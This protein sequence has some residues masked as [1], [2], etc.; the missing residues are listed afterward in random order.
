M[1]FVSRRGTACPPFPAGKVPGRR[2]AGRRSGIWNGSLPARRSRLSPA[3][4]GVDAW[5]TAWGAPTARNDRR[6]ASDDG[7]VGAKF[8]RRSSWEEGERGLQAPHH[9]HGYAILRPGKSLRHFRHAIRRRTTICDARYQ[10]SI[11]VI[12]PGLLHRRRGPV[13]SNCVQI[14]VRRKFWR[15]CRSPRFDPRSKP[16]CGGVDILRGG[17]AP[18]PH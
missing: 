9:Q 13:R 1:K 6:R 16:G 18:H 4:K 3:R 2:P 17:A 12:A 10:L 8:V 15:I 11:A 14:D 7:Q 5:A